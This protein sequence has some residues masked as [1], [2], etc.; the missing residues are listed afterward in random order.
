MNTKL[1]YTLGTDKY[2]V[3]SVEGTEPPQGVTNGNWYRYVIGDGSS[4][5]EGM[6]SGSL[7]T[8]TEHAHDV[9]RDLNERAARGGSFYSPRQ[10]K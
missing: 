7:A 5:I 6:K 1:E 10:R 3:V 9:A 4:K 8:V 2:R